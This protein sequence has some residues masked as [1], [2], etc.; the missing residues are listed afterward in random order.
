VTPP[1]QTDRAYIYERRGENF[2][3]ILREYNKNY[4]HLKLRSHKPLMVA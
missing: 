2:I 3:K 1:D 4:L